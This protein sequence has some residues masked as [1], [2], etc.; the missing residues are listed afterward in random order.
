MSLCIVVY[1]GLGVVFPE[2]DG[3]WYILLLQIPECQLAQSA[4][5]F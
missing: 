4:L 3:H 5:V 2:E 1:I